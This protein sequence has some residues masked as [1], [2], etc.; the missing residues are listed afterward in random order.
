MV[1]G[2]RLAQEIVKKIPKVMGEKENVVVEDHTEEILK[3]KRFLLVLNDV[4]ANY[5]DDGKKL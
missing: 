5:D 4:W 3:H 2:V 1:D